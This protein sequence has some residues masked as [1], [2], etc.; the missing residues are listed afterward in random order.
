MTLGQAVADCLYELGTRIPGSAQELGA[1]GPLLLGTG[2]AAA[3][4][5]LPA[6][7]RDVELLAGVV[8]QTMLAANYSP[9]DMRKANQHD[10]DLLLRRLALTRH[11]AGRVLGF[12]RRVLWRLNR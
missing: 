5:N 9:A 3:S 10:L 1:T 11:D 6:S 12:F 2:G 7:T 4:D 8:E